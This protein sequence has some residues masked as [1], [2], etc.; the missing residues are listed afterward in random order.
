MK[1]RRRI[2]SFFLLGSLFVSLFSSCEETVKQTEGKKDHEPVATWDPTESEETDRE[3]EE[4]E[5]VPKAGDFIVGKLKI[6]AFYQ[7]LFGDYVLAAGVKINVKE[8]ESD[9]ERV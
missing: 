6:D 7:G 4:T 2:I 8:Y 1:M 5:Y 3:P 9:W